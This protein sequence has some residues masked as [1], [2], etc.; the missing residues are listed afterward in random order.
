VRQL[1]RDTDTLLAAR[2]MNA[3]MVGVMHEWV[4]R[5]DAYDLKRAAPRMI[6]MFLAGLREEPPRRAAVAART[7]RARRS[8][9][10]ARMTSAPGL[11]D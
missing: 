7:A 5:P 11:N 3:F 2:C 6:D 8:R 10:R 4:Q 9:G 1:P